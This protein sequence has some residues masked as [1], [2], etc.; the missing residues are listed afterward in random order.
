MWASASLP[1]TATSTGKATFHPGKR[2]RDKA[3]HYARLRKRLQQKGTRGAKRRL[4][5]IEQRER[6]LKAQANHTLATQIIKQHAHALIGL[7]QLTDIRERTK[8]K[9]RQRKKNGKGNER[10]SEKARHPPIACTLSGPLPNCMPSS[11]TRQRFRD[12]WLSR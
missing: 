1:V 11:A 6:R 4:K 10:V 8:R 5:R 7:E 9:K 3:N 12:H 2:V